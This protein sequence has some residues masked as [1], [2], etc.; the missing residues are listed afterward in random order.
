M[1]RKNL[2]VLALLVFSVLIVSCAVAEDTNEMD[3]RIMSIF[4]VDGDWVSLARAT[5][6]SPG[7]VE[8]TLE[9]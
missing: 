6:E 8:G 5:G 4:R 7:A 2:V 1:F 9:E 3:A